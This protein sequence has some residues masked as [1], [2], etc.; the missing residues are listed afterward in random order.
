MRGSSLSGPEWLVAYEADVKGWLPSA[1]KPNHVDSSPGFSELKR[2][3]ISFYDEKVNYPTR[4]LLYSIEKPE[5][6]IFS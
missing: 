4:S 6:S 1:E 2:A 3:G 5:P